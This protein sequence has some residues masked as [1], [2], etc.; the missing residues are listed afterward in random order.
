[1]SDAYEYELVAPDELHN[2]QDGDILIDEDGCRWECAGGWWRLQ[3]TH[4]FLR[5]EELPA[6]A[7]ALFRLVVFGGG[8]FVVGD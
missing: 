5:S 4:T 6:S 1:M 7:G 2:S 8:G 3:H